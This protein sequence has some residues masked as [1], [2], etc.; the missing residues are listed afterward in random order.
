M[1]TIGQDEFYQHVTDFLKARGIELTDGAYTRHIRRACGLLSDA[2]NAA[3]RTVKR[4]RQEVDQKL[5]Q[6][7]QSIHEATAPEPPP[8]KPPPLTPEPPP[9]S[10]PP[11]SPRHAA[12]RPPRQ[13][14][15]QNGRG[16]SP[17]R[18][19]RLLEPDRRRIRRNAGGA[20]RQVAS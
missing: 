14:A 6:L 16:K 19:D 5:A 17:P 10:P 13:P 18:Q 12:R 7:R 2:L 20:S 3:Q 1:K 8:A 15:H 11:R 4:A 9:V